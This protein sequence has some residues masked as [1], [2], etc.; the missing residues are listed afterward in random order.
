MDHPVFASNGT[1]S[2]LAPPIGANPAGAV[3]REA[4][5]AAGARDPPRGQEDGRRTPYSFAVDG[6]RIGGP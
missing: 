3:N 1:R 2:A 5:S 6:G 4:A